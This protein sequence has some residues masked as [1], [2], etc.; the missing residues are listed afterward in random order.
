METASLPIHILEELG[1][2]TSTTLSIAPDREEA[3]PALKAFHILVISAA[4]AHTNANIKANVSK[5]RF[6][7][8]LY[9]KY[10]VCNQKYPRCV[11]KGRLYSR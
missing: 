3:F 5:S 7:S 10:L 8:F 1:K 9:L 11:Y 4:C 6:I 2:A